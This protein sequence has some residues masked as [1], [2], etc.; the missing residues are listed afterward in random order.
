M[1]EY[2]P[3]FVERNGT[4]MLSVLGILSSCCAG[5]TAYFLR[6]RC[7]KITCCG[8]SCEREVLAVTVSDKV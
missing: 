5:M 6:S 8:A 1:S 4:W 3:D 7:T 2:A